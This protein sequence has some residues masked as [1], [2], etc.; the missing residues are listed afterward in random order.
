MHPC[1]HQHIHACMHPSMNPCMHASIHESMYL[2]TSMR[3]STHESMY[4]LTSMQPLFIHYSSLPLLIFP[5]IHLYNYPSLSSSLLPSL[6]QS[7][8]LS[9]PVSIHSPNHPRVSN[10]RAYPQGFHCCMHWISPGPE[11]ILF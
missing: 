3:P 7:I 6:H 8:C 9:K 1:I 10:P 5:L 11:L 4:L 2:L